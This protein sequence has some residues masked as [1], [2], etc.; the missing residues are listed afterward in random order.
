VA[1]EK[2][3]TYL[4]TSH[5]YDASASLEAMTSPIFRAASFWVG[6]TSN[7]MMINE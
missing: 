1:F 6:M 2:G 3:E 5:A 4:P 7:D